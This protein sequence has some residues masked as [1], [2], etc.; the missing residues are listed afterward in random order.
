MHLRDLSARS[1]ATWT[2]SQCYTG[3]DHMPRVAPSKMSAEV[4]AGAAE[5]DDVMDPPDII[6][7]RELQD[8]PRAVLARLQETRQPIVVTE[9]GKPAG[10]LLVIGEYNQ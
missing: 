10:V 7:V 5:Q 1:G 4:V 8:N 9:D 3:L 2:V 6:A